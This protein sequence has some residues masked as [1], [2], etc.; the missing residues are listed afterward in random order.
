MAVVGVAA[1]IDLLF[2]NGDSDLREGLFGQQSLLPWVIPVLSAVI[3]PLLLLRWHYPRT[4]FAVHCTYTLAAGLLL[5]D[6]LPF[7]GLLVALYAMSSRVTRG[8]SLFGVG[9]SLVPFAVNAYNVAADRPA[10]G[11]R[12]FAATMLLW[13]VLNLT[14]WGLGRRA[15]TAE[16]QIEHERRMRETQQAQAAE[17]VRR[18]RLYLARE[19]HDIVSHSVNAM[20]LQS[21]GIRTLVPSAEQQIHDA[22][23]AMETTGVEAM[24]ELHRLLG[25]L[26]AVSPADENDQAFAPKSLR[27]LHAL[28]NTTRAS[29]V[30]VEFEVEGDPAKLDR[31]IELTAYRIVQEALTNTIRHAGPGAS[32]RIQVRWEPHGLTLTVQ[33]RTGVPAQGAARLS[34]G[35]G[36]EG[37]LERVSLVGGTLEAR[38]VAGGFLV[39]AHLPVR[40]Q[41]TPRPGKPAGP[42]F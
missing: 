29:G 5:P 28:I 12:S 42:A 19:L 30:D 22:L 10:Q 36:L 31:S 34:S 25:L 39:Q 18:E 41:G 9:A 40:P 32:T 38:S 24:D 35:H 21:A 26:R 1:G 7:M 3:Y 16:R 37:L 8:W 20:I 6:Y 17:A 11:P 27:D 2:W 15:Y 4:V 13:A 23:K 14:V 33:D